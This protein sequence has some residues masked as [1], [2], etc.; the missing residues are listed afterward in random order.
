MQ[1]GCLVRLP[2][3]LKVLVLQVDSPKRAPHS[4]GRDYVPPHH[5]TVTIHLKPLGACRD[6]SET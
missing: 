2:V 4:M 5:P 6:S 3:A 1:M